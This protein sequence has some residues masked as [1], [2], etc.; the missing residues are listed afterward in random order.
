MIAILQESLG[1]DKEDD[2]RLYLEIE[3]LTRHK[4]YIMKNPG[5]IGKSYLNNLIFKTN[6]NIPEKQL[7]FC[8]TW[9][10]KCSNMRR[11]YGV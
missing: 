8:N 11:T 1:T 5:A 2:E 6:L 9:A 10:N 7:F 3:T 4:E